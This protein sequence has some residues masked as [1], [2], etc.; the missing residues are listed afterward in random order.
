VTESTYDGSLWGP[1]VCRCGNHVDPH[2]HTE[3][4]P[5]GKSIYDEGDEPDAD[6]LAASCA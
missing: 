6:D 1:D 5:D 2:R 4:D 3:A